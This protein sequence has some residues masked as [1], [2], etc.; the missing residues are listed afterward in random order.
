LEIL[1]NIRDAIDSKESKT[2][3][4]LNYCIKMITSNQLY[5]ANIELDGPEGQ[6]KDGNNEVL[7]LLNNYSSK[8]QADV[9]KRRP[10][11]QS[12]LGP[13][14]DSANKVEITT[15]FVEKTLAIN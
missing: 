15:E 11:T 13:S 7:L 9:K 14:I 5:E 4:E 1:N 6:K 3:Q 10:S 8:K 12:T 2:I